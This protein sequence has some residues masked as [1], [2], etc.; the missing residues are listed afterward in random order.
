MH[1]GLPGE[2]LPWNSHP[3]YRRNRVSGG[4]ANGQGTTVC[5]ATTVTDHPGFC[6]ADTREE[7]QK[8]ILTSPLCVPVHVLLNQ[9]QPNLSN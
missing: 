8:A 3:A 1:T 7:G 4:F 6:P 9:K 2:C 5:P